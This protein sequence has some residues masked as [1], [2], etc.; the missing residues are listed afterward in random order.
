[1]QGHHQENLFSLW[2]RSRG[3]EWNWTG[4]EENC[5]SLILI[6]T[7]TFTPSHT[8][9]LRRCFHTLTLWIT[10][11]CYLWMSLWLWIRAVRDKDFIHVYF[12]K[13]NLLNLKVKLVILKLCLFLLLLLTHV[14]FSC[15]LF[16]VCKKISL[17]SDLYLCFLLSWKMFPII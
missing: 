16:H 12:F 8:L 6:L 3:S 4:T 15:R 9:S 10:W 2:R 1:M 11:S 5:R 7:H 14:Y 17:F 13:R